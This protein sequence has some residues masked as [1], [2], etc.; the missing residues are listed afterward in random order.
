MKILNEQMNMKYVVRIDAFPLGTR[1]DAGNNNKI[2]N[3]K[4]KKIGVSKTKMKENCN[5]HGR[6]KCI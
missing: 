4:I 1:F 2:C 5:F 3:G 6:Y